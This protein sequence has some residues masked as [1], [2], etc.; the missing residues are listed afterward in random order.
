[1]SNYLSYYYFLNGNYLSYYCIAYL[2]IIIKI[3]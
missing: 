1:M 2:Q 3:L